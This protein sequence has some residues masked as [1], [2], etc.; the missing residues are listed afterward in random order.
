MPHPRHFLYFLEKKEVGA[1]M[2]P[3]CILRK[4]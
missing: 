2:A 1:M 3:T 4:K